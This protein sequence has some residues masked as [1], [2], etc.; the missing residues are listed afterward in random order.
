MVVLVLSHDLFVVRAGYCASRAAVEADVLV[1]VVIDNRTVIHVGHERRPNMDHRSVVEEPASAPVA[2]LEAVAV[3]PETVMDTAVESDVPSPITFVPPV[4]TVAPAPE[5]G[6][7]EHAHLR[8]KNPRS[9]DPVIRASIIIPGPIAR[10]PE[11]ALLRA[12]RLLIDRQ[13]R[14]RKI[15]GHT[16]EHAGRRYGRQRRQRE[17]RDE[18]TKES[19]AHEVLLGPEAWIGGAEPSLNLSR[20]PRSLADPLRLL[21]ATVPRMIR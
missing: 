20:S 5:A 18:T 9:G 6:R 3:I 2:A 10:R 21:Q 8:R 12:G 19:D 16:D 1:G 7:P 17:R 14:G 11:I 13:R 15:D 4:G